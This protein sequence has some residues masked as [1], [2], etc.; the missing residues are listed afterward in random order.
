MSRV[1]AAFSE[2]AA[3]KKL[4]DVEKADVR[5]VSLAF[6]LNRHVSIL[7]LAA[8]RAKSLESLRIFG[9]SL[10]LCRAPMQIRGKSLADRRESLKNRR[11]RLEALRLATW[12]GGNSPTFLK[13]HVSS[14]KPYLP[15]GYKLFGL[16]NVIMG[17]RCV[18]TSGLALRR[19]LEIY[20]VDQGA[21][22]AN[23]PLGPGS[24][25]L[26]FRIC[27]M[28][29]RGRKARCCTPACCHVAPQAAAR[30]P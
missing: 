19:P 25:G 4:D 16:N 30:T 26:R 24:G 5:L 22:Y 2:L 8:Q 13:P 6:F 20:R 18:V 14:P 23:W 17:E 10:A 7:K 27:G 21:S 28:E 12:V 15:E 3:L 1:S 29:C 9:E 11:K